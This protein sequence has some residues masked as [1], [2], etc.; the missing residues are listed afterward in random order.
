MLLSPSAKALIATLCHLVPFRSHG[1]VTLAL[2]MLAS[3]AFNGQSCLI[4]STIRGL[5]GLDLVSS[6]MKFMRDNRAPAGL[7]ISL[8]YWKVSPEH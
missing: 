7:P 8:C 6:Q 1:W 5:A 2:L 3:A 4:T